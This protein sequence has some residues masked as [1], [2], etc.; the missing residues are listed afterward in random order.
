MVAGVINKAG[1]ASAANA[2]IAK[3]KRRYVNTK[4]ENKMSIFNRLTNIFKS[5]VNAVLGKVEDTEKMLNQTVLDMQQQLMKA[6]QQVAV[7]IADEKRLERQYKEHRAQAVTWMEKA[8]LAVGRGHDELAKPAL[9]RKIEYEGLA[10]EY[11]N[12]RDTQKAAVEKR[13]EWPT[14]TIEQIAAIQALIQDSQGSVEDVARRFKGARR[15][16]VARH[17]E[18]LTIIGEA[19]RTKDGRYHAVS[20]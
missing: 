14:T 11:K 4:K 2:E 5:E 18:T 15:T 9:E 16:L 17:L 1:V 19:R 3:H 10:A 8:K 7:A 12:Q 6:K 20:P 13:A